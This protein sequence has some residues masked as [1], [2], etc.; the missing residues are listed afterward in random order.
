[1]Y[2]CVPELLAFIDPVNGNAVKTG[3]QMQ[4]TYAKQQMQRWRI[5]RRVFTRP[6]QDITNRKLEITQWEGSILGVQNEGF[7]ISDSMLTTQIRG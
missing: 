1:M 6:K 2:K 5:Y 7:D 4:S 3:C